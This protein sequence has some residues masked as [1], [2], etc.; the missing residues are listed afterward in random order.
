VG[1]LFF[2][3]LGSGVLIIIGNYV[4]LFPGE[5]ENWRLFM[6]LLLMGG[7]FAVATQWH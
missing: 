3:L 2:T 5:T 6:G 4:G 7:S 1:A